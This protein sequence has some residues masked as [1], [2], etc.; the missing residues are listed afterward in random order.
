MSEDTKE[1][2]KVL[3]ASECSRRKRTEIVIRFSEEESF[4]KTV[5]TWQQIGYIREGEK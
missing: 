2:E 5:E 4:G 1:V 3:N